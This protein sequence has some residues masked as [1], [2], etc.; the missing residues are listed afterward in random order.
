MARTV[1]KPYRASDLLIRVAG[2]DSKFD[3]YLDTL[4][5]DRKSVV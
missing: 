2:V 5:A 4:V 3:V 1:G